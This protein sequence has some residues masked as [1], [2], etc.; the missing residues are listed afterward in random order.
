MIVAAFDPHFIFWNR[1]EA[2]FWIFIALAFA[3]AATQRTSPRLDCVIAAIAFALFGVSD[4]VETT[5]GA[6]WRPW[7][8]FAWKAACVLAFLILL[9]RHLR[10]RRL[11]R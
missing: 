5:T 4:L 8:L 6:W 7:W 2:V 10:R 1:V 9:A 3:I 11:S